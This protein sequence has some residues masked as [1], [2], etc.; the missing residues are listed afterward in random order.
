M[1]N[2]ERTERMIELEVDLKSVSVACDAIEDTNILE[3]DGELGERLEQVFGMLEELKFCFEVEIAET[4]NTVTDEELAEW[5]SDNKA[6][7]SEY[8][9]SVL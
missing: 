4:E 3:T 6:M 2:L 5:E 9:R 8:I 7:I 1:T